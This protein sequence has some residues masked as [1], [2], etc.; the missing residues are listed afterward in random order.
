MR[1]QNVVA[2]LASVVA[3][4]AAPAAIAQP[5]HQATRAATPVK[6]KAVIHGHPNGNSRIAGK[7]TFTP[8]AV[9]A[10]VV[11]IEVE[12][13]DGGFGSMTINGVTTRT[14]GPNKGRAVIKV[15]FKKP[16][17]YFATAT[18]TTSGITGLLKVRA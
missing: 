12:N 18:D 14:M 17:V 6:V 9:H 1:A 7:I 3:L 13:L 5:T 8:A 16:G 4:L 11:T 2:G 15:N 10:G